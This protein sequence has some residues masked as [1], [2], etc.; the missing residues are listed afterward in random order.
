LF[1]QRRERG[2][3]VGFDL[4]GKGGGHGVWWLAQFVAA[5]AS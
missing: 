4:G 3:L 5:P 1:Q 2:G